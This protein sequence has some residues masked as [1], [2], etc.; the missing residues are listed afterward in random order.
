[1]R[2]RSVDGGASNFNQIGDRRRHTGAAAV[3]IGELF[4]I[5]TKSVTGAQA[6]AN[7][8]PQCGLAEQCPSNQIG[9]S[10][11][12]AL[13]NAWSSGLKELFQVTTNR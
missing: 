3:W 8:L 2:C 13:A 1:M 10:G 7:A 11:A 12:Q 6:L 9:A 4:R 5:P